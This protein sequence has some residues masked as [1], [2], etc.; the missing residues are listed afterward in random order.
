MSFLPETA[1]LSLPENYR[2]CLFGLILAGGGFATLMC[3]LPWYVSV[4]VVWATDLYVI[5][6]LVEM[7]LRSDVDAVRL[8]QLP[9]RLWSIPLFICLVTAVV[10]SFANRYIQSESVRESS[11]PHRILSDRL[12]ATYFSI[13]TITTLGYGDY[14]PADQKSRKLVMCELGNGFLLLLF[15]FPVLAS[16]LAAMAA[17]ATKTLL[18]QDPRNSRR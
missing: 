15:A 10:C 3:S 12:D 5:A 2:H 1:R 9:H 11:D 14:V 8:F 17:E 18:Q 7:G 16:R 13:V 6:I 4:G